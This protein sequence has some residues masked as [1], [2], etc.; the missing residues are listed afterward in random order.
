MSQIPASS[1]NLARIAKACGI[2]PKCD[3]RQVIG[4]LSVRVAGAE[5]VRVAQSF[6][7]LALLVTPLS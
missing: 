1:N 7:D 2:K 4:L 3:V 5:L 6:I